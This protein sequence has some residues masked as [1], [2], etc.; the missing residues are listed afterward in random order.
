VDA[1]RYAKY[2]PHDGFNF[3]ALC[4]HTANGVRWMDHHQFGYRNPEK[5]I[6]FNGDMSGVA[7][8]TATPSGKA[9]GARAINPGVQGIDDFGAYTADQGLG[10]NEISRFMG[11]WG[12]DRNANQKLDRG[13][14]PKSVRLR[15][16]TVARFNYYDMRVPAT[17]R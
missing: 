13:Q 3:Q 11:R 1:G 5:M 10:T 9:A 7:T 2:A 17:I 16:V 4:G 8:G 12:A 14:V 15:A 6:I